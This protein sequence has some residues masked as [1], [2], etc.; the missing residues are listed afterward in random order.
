[1]VNIYIGDLARSDARM[2]HRALSYYSVV[3]VGPSYREM[4][5]SVQDNTAATKGFNILI[6][7]LTPGLP[8]FVS[9]AINAF[10]SDGA[11]LELCHQVPFKSVL[12]A[13]DVLFFGPHTPQNRFRD[14]C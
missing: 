3:Y 9:I 4:A 14:I 1:V 10:P 2:D 12:Q 5:A 11:Q 13:A 6:V 7:V 8:S